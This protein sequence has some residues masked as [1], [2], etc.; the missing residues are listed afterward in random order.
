MNQNQEFGEPVQ[1][2]DGIGKGVPVPP[3]A[4][5]NAELSKAL[6]KIYSVVTGL[7]V[8]KLPDEIVERW[9]AE[10]ATGSYDF[11]VPTRSSREALALIV[12]AGRFLVNAQDE[13][14]RSVVAELLQ[15]ALKLLPQEISPNE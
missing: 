4:D 12:G 1:K 11:G 8:I 3:T 13:L 7:G 14:D 6:L 15:E 10:E 5:A 9:A 2:A